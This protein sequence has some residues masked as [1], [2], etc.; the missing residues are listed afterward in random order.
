ME[1]ARMGVSGAAGES[2][3]TDDGYMTFSMKKQEASVRAGSG[4][5]G[6]LWTWTAG[7]L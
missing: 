2:R 6:E 7:A 5:W 3:N 4:T 1:R